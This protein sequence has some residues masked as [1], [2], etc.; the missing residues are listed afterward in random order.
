MT[1]RWL[2]AF[3]CVG[4]AVPVYAQNQKPVDINIVKVNGT[5]V[6]ADTPVLANALSTTVVTISSGAAELQSYF[7]HNPSAATAFV[8]MFDISGTV[9]LGTSTPKWSIGIPAGQSGN[10]SQMNLKFT[11]AIKVAATTTA[12]GSSA[13]ATALVCN[14]GVQP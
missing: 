13:P 8:Q 9:T 12:T 7:C 14:F 1:N 10:L 3:V 4:F 2:I 11:N 6:A 5:T